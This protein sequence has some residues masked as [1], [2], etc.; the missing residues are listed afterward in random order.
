MNTTITAKTL[1]DAQIAEVAE[2]AKA[3]RDQDMI[4]ACREAVGGI[5]DAVGQASKN[6]GINS[7]RR[8]VAAALSEPGGYFGY[9]GR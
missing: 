6:V 4:T 1:T 8:R 9:D 5:P 7:G 2:R 3:R